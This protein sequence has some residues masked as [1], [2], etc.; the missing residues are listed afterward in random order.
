MIQ[1]VV[2]AVKKESTSDP[3]LNSPCES[4]RDLSKP[5]WK[6]KVGVLLYKNYLESFG[7]EVRLISDEGD[8]EYCLPNSSVWIRDEVKTASAVMEY[9]K[10]DKKYTTSHWFN[11]AQTSNLGMLS[12]LLLYSHTTIKSLG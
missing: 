8:I 7:C 1:Q 6:G 11:Q 2:Q 5:Q 12:H 10:R 9:R 4:F 3:W